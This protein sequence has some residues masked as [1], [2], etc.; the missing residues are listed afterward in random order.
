MNKTDLIEA[1]EK[2]DGPSRDE[3]IAL[4]VLRDYVERTKNVSGKFSITMTHENLVMLVGML[5]DAKETEVLFDKMWEA[6]MRAI[7]LWQQETG[8]Y[9]TWP[10]RAKYTEWM[11]RRKSLADAALKAEQSN[12]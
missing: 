1:L 10:D 3:E 5:E 4:D 6:D 2:A 12:G 7:E 8:R 9:L 11:L